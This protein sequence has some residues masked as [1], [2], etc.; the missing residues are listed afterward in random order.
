MDN[1]ADPLVVL[2]DILD[3]VYWLTRIKTAPTVADAAYTPELERTRGK[4][5][6]TKLSMPTLTRAWQLMLKGVGEVQSA[7]NAVQ[8]AQMTLVRLAHASVLPSP[9]ALVRQLTADASSGDPAAP[10]PSSAPQLGAST[11]LPPSP[12]PPDSAPPGG[13]PTASAGTSPAVATAESAP[14]DPEPS[15]PQPDDFKSVVDSENAQ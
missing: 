3:V 2:Q 14:A 4:D 5:M 8:A 11:P 7:P 12:P 9:A 6:A 10:V 13:G 15:T 1:D